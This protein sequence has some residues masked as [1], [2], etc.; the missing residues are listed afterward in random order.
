[1]HVLKRRKPFQKKCENSILTPCPASF[2]STSP[3]RL[4]KEHIVIAVDE[5]LHDNCT[6]SPSVRSQISWVE[7]GIFQ[8]KELIFDKKYKGQQNRINHIYEL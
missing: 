1:M 3:L 6:K 5:K 4:I 8:F 7:A 2:L